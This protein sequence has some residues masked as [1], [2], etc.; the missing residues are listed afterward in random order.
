MYYQGVGDINM[1]HGEGWGHFNCNGREKI[2]DPVVWGMT[3]SI[4]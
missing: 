3:L 1:V 2:T 4:E